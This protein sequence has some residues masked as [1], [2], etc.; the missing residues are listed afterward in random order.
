MT[1]AQAERI[2]NGVVTADNEENEMFAFTCM[3]D[4]TAVAD[5]LDAPKLRLGTCIDS[6]TSQD[7]CSDCSKFTNYKPV[8]RKITMADGRTLNA[9]RMGDLQLELPNGKIKTKM[10]FKNAIHA[11]ET[12]FTLILI[13]RLD[14][15]GFAVN[16]KKGMC[17][18]NNP[19]GKT[20]ATIPHSDGLYKIAARK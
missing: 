9:V 3:S 4:Y 16:F 12:A 5:D 13:S 17:S 2:Q 8:D 19:K 7:Y 10:I 6:G 11:P 14:K 15:A 1:Q 18:I 20:V